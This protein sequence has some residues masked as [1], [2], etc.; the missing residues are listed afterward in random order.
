MSGPIDYRSARDQMTPH[1]RRL[2]IGL[3]VGPLVLA[4]ILLHIVQRRRDAEREWR[5]GNGGHCYSNLKQIGQAIYLYANENRD[6]MPPDLV[7][8]IETEDLVPEVFVCR[9]SDDKRTAATQPAA[10]RADFAAGGYCSY[11]YVAG[12]GPYS[13]LSPFEVIA[14]EPAGHHDGRAA[15]LLGDGRVQIVNDATATD[16]AR[17]FDA[18]TRPIRVPSR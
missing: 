13:K 10:I 18:G 17:Q 5:H 8:L 1:G 14:F 3:I 2:A 4:M 16:I 11:F 12:L 7:A 15:V 9:S 6:A